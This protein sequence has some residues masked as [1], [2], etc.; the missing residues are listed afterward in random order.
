MPSANAEGGN[1][2]IPTK[3]KYPLK[4]S[5]KPILEL[6]KT[7]D[8]EC[9]DSLL[10]ILIRTHSEGILTA[11]ISHL[12]NEISK[13]TRFRKGRIAFFRDTLKG[14]QSPVTDQCKKNRDYAM[15]FAS[16]YG[17]NSLNIKDK[18]CECLI[19]GKEIPN[20]FSHDEFKQ[21]LHNAYEIFKGMR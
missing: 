19:T 9:D 14:N 16:K 3:T 20:Q 10:Y 4:E 1:E 6:L 13:G 15:A 11:A 17:W 8:L 21:M 12:L 7:L 2:K 5:Q 18:Y